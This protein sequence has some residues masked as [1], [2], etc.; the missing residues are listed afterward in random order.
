MYEYGA[1]NPVSFVDA[2]GLRPGGRRPPRRRRRRGGRNGGYRRPPSIA[3]QFLERVFGYKSFRFSEHD[4]F[5]GSTALYEAG[6]HYVG[7]EPYPGQRHY[8]FER[9]MSEH[10]IVRVTYDRGNHD[11]KFPCETEP[12]WRYL[13]KTRGGY[14]AQYR[15]N[16]GREVEN[17]SPASHIRAKRTFRPDRYDWVELPGNVF[18]RTEQ[19]FHVVRKGDA[20][21]GPR[22]SYIGPGE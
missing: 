8:N 1:N 9:E 20:I 5:S 15:D 7:P 2:E 13:T 14:N 12:H 22:R 4:L 16:Q 3:E 19:E 17:R 11:A 18:R 21:I 6:F 10:E